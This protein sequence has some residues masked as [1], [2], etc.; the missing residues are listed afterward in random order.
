MTTTEDK[1]DNI[2]GGARA[3]DWSSGV[4]L[5]AGDMFIGV[6]QP[7][8][9]TDGY[10]RGVEK[11]RFLL[12]FCPACETWHHPRR[13]MCHGCQS[14][15]LTW[16]QASGEGSV[17]SF[18]EVHRAPDVF[19]AA[20][21]Y[22]VGVARLREGVHLFTRFIASDNDK[23]VVDAP[24]RVDFRVLEGGVLLPVFVVDEGGQ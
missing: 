3:P 5:R 4:E 6:Y 7:S 17:Y 15:E 24:V 13:I 10:W 23:M 8:P 9:E 14:V 12:K 18:S 2:P 1:T 19:A 11:G 21:P 20:T 22:V 16:K